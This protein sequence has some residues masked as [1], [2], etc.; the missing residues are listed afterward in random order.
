MALY[1]RLPV[2]QDT[3]KLVLKLFEVTRDFPREYKYTPGQDIKRD[4]IELVRSIYR[5]TRPMTRMSL[6]RNFWIIL[7]YLNWRYVCVWI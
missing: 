5:P 4:G 7:K 3:Y 2:Y 6:W 1:Y